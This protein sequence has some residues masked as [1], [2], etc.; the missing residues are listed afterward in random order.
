MEPRLH[1]VTPH[2]L[3]AHCSRYSLEEWLTRAELRLCSRFRAE[4]RQRDWLAGRL[5]AKKLIQR[6]FQ[7]TREFTLTHIEITNDEVGA[8][9]VCVLGDGG[10]NISI[11]HSEGHG[12]AGFAVQSRLGVDLQKIRPVRPGLLERILSE[13]ERN[14]LTKHF[15]AREDE[16]VTL[17]WA[18]KEAVMKAQRA[19]IAPRFQ[20]IEITVIE[21][22]RAEICIGN[23]KLSAHWGQREGFIFAFAPQL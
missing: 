23:K 14:Q 15:A 1:W 10:L 7:K 17:F 13:R 6:H 22:G 2:D 18:L 9:I 4:R 5:A 8:P 3:E 16:G 21:P 20:E 11:S 12:L 19:R